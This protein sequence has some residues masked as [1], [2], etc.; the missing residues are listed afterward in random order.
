MSTYI[1]SDG[2]EVKISGCRAD[3]LGA[4]FV[5]IKNGKVIRTTDYDYQEEGSD[6]KDIIVVDVHEDGTCTPVEVEVHDDGTCEVVAVWKRSWEKTEE[7]RETDEKAYRKQKRLD[8]KE[9]KRLN[10]WIQNLS[11]CW[12]KQAEVMT[13]EDL[14]SKCKSLRRLAYFR[15]A[16]D[17]YLD[18]VDEGD[19]DTTQTLHEKVISLL[20]EQDNSGNWYSHE[21]MVDSYV[22]WNWIHQ[23]IVA[24]IQ[25]NTACMAWDK[26]LLSGRYYV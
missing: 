18:A 25:C 26:D 21:D 20:N 3:V 13:L 17:I 8:A 12:A 5:R 14:V 22:H 2:K 6:G 1:S 19:N 4:D 9:K 24:V 23:Y 7:E 11:E 16:Q 15:M 10:Y